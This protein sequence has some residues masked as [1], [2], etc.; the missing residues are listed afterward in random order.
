V[1]KAGLLVAPQLGSPATSNVAPQLGSPATSNVAPQLGSP[2][3]SNGP[4]GC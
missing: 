4:A 3:T 2:A 1:L